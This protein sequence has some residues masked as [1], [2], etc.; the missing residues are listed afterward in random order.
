MLVYQGSIRQGKTRLL[1]E[2]MLISPKS[3]P[4]S[5]IALAEIDIHVIIIKMA[6]EFVYI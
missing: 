1:Q 3:L 4:L 6:L 5:L 2:L